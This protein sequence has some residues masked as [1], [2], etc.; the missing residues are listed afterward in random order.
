MNIPKR[1]LG[2]DCWMNSGNVA[3]KDI[4]YTVAHDGEVIGVRLD[5]DDG[6]YQASLDTEYPHI[7]ASKRVPKGWAHVDPGGME[8]E[9][10]SIILDYYKAKFQ[11]R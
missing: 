9:E 2:A 8:F 11:N 6:K 7:S 1:F 3:D 4:R 10:R 5:L